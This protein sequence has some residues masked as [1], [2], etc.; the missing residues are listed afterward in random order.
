MQNQKNE[1]LKKIFIALL[2]TALFV[3]SYYYYSGSE[4][5]TKLTDKPKPAKVKQVAE[6]KTIK[7]EVKQIKQVKEAVKEVQPEEVQEVKNNY[8]K[9]T[10]IKDLISSAINSA[11][12]SDPFSY[13]ESRYSPFSVKSHI[14]E[15]SDLPFPPKSSDP[16]SGAPAD[17][18]MIKGFLGEKVIAEIKGL[19]EALAINEILQGVKVLK[20]DPQNLKCEFEIEGKK[21]KKTM[22]P[23]TRPNDNVELNYIHN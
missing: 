2:V 4:K 18:V 9:P 1:N 12:K 7:K 8:I 14:K 3:G 15:V 17:G 6:K 21:V 23:V 5:E 11:G 22:Q 10:D 16:L 19:T 13:K 20:I